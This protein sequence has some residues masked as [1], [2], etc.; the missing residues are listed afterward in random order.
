LTAVIICSK[1]LSRICILLSKEVIMSNTV[2]V[3]SRY[4]IALPSDARHQLKIEAGDRL[5]VD[6]QDGMIILIPL[7]D[8]YADALAGRHREI[9]AD[10]DTD[11]YLRQER[12]AWTNSATNS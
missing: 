8:N 1:L 5:L 12:E 7:P 4:Q 3:S 11:A 9:W 10:V 6:V 2:K